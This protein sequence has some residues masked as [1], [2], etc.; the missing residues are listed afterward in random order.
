MNDPNTLIMTSTN[1][2]EEE[3]EYLDL[4]QTVI[5]NG[6]VRQTRNSVCRTLFGGSLSFDLSENK[7][8]ILTTKKMSFRNIFYEL[9]WFL[10]GDCNVQFLQDN[11][12]KIWDGN[13][14]Q[15]GKKDL[16]PIY[17]KQFRSSGPKNIDQI[18]YC[19][20]LIKNKPTSRRIVMT[21]WN[22][23]DIPDM[24]LP[25]CHGTVV[26]FFVKG[27]YLSLQMYQRSADICLGLPYNITSYSL[28]L[29]MMAH[30]TGL[31][32][33]KMRIVLGDG[34][35]YEPHIE[36]AKEQIKRFP[37]AFPELRIKADVKHEDPKYF[38]F[39]DFVLCDYQHHSPI[40]YEFVV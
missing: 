40:K 27:E 37:L 24:A 2:N 39:T 26:Q 14:E 28:L 17:G 12:V 31:I 19:L 38:K 13:A 30:C 25:P 21:T 22:P 23:S 18:A 7:L 33:G 35:I 34:H 16:G 15:W 20:D 5:E 10:M 9:K 29:I 36:P 3:M 6:D 4:M 8:P 1:H 32:P 11:N